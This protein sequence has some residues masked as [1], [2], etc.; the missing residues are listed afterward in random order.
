[1]KRHLFITT[2][3]IFYSVLS[4]FSQA[5]TPCATTPV[6]IGS[7]CV[8]VIHDASGDTQS[9]VPNPSCDGYYPGYSNEDT[10]YSFVA[11][12]SGNVSIAIGEIAGGEYPYMS[13]AVYTGPCGSLTAANEVDC[14]GG[15]PGSAFPTFDLTALT[16]GQTYYV[17]VWGIDF[18]LDGD[19]RVHSFCAYEPAS[20][21]V[22]DDCISATIAVVDTTGYCNQTTPGTIAGATQ[23]SESY[24]CSFAGGGDANDDVWFSFVATETTHYFY[25]DNIVGSTTDLSYSVH[26]GTFC[27][28][29][30]VN[31]IGCNTD[32]VTGLTIGNT[33]LVR[34]WSNSSSSQTSTFE[35]CITAPPVEPPC[36]VNP[37]AGNTAC[38]ATPICNLNGYCG[39]TSATYT[40]DSWT[41]LF[42]AA[43]SCFPDIDNN[44]FL[45]LTAID[46]EIS[47]W[48]WVDNCSLPSGIQIMIFSAANCGSGPIAV[49]QCYS[50]GVIPVEAT[51]VTAD[52]LTIG[53]QYYIMIDGNAGAVCDY[54][55]AAHEGI[56]LPVE[57]AS[58]TGD[59]AICLGESIDIYATGGA[60]GS[61]N[62]SPPTGLSSTVADTVTSTPATAGTY[63]YSVLSTSVSPLCPATS[64]DFTLIVDPCVLPVEL[65]LFEAVYKNEIVELSW[66][67]ASEMNNDFFTIERSSNLEDWTF[68]DQVKGVGNTTYT[69]NYSA[70][71]KRPLTGVNYYRLKQTD[72]NGA[73]E[74]FNIRAVTVDKF[75]IQIYPNPAINE[76]TI[77]A[78]WDNIQEYA[79]LDRLGKSVT[80]IIEVTSKQDPFKK[81]FDI[82]ALPKGVYYFHTNES[83]LKIIKL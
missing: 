48:V 16:P 79:I 44:S 34:V 80:S 23:S 56:E 81:V 50:P 37:A 63:T 73:F 41:E 17:R 53:N 25:L 3:S 30:G 26:E 9:A 19:P 10:W 55:I 20:P 45:E 1:M 32:F 28:T 51:L 76:I 22:N 43:T 59:S 58:T 82:S 6:T 42:N 8:P 36:A 74:Y 39:T 7:A 14:F 66:S 40:D 70:I 71:D 11:P 61:Y 15:P 13:A 18:S 31:S 35:L 46:T 62:W 60:S 77:N 38:A 12:A 24:Y 47:F 68:I 72:I 29:T 33:Y 52:G 27:G 5:D 2:I 65:V 49:H 21:P 54:T 83:N 4:V 78:D 64:S 75:D 67:T 69:T 57:A